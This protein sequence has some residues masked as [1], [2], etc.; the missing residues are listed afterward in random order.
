MVDQRVYVSRIV[1]FLTD[2][3]MFPVGKVNSDSDL[4]KYHLTILYWL[5]IFVC[6]NHIWALE[7]HMDLTGLFWL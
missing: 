4:T 3:G 1:Y 7:R 5:K 2:Y 6:D